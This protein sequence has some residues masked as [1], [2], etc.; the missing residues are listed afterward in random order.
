MS[1]NVDYEIYEGWISLLHIHPV[2]S[3]G[4]DENY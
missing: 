4:N 2:Y 1:G 3:K